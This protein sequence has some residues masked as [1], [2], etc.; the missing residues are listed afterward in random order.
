[1]SRRWSLRLGAA[2]LALLTVACG[3]TPEPGIARGKDL[4]DTCVPCHGANGGGNQT[5]GAPRIAGL[6][7]W[8]VEAQLAGFQAGN[9]GYDAFDTV[10]IKMKTISWTLDL[11]GDIG[12][13]AAYVASLSPALP[14]SQTQGLAGDPE[15]GR[16]VWTTCAVCHG[17]D[18]RGNQNLRAPPLAGQADWYLHR[19]LRNFRAG[20]RGTRRTDAWGAVMRPNAGTLD[21]A[22]IANVVAYIRTLK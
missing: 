18:A 19:Q 4:Y 17:A 2:P 20:W 16:Q 12:S 13:V 9:R 3:R 22:A 14:V 15:A 21:D 8:Y 1:M 7:Q 10:G 11:E 6:P 5:L